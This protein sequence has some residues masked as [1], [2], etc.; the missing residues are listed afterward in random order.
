MHEARIDAALVDRAL[1][2]G[3]RNAFGQLVRRHQSVIRA[4]LRRLTQGDHARAD[5]LAQETFLKA[6]RSL[7]QFRGEA[8]FSTWLHRIA[9]TI[10]LQETRSRNNK[11]LPQTHL[12]T[13]TTGESGRHELRLDVLA[14]MARLAE[15]E[16]LALLHCYHLD[17][18][19]EEAAF[20]LRIPVGTVKTH[21][22]RGKV[23]MK[24][25]LAAWN[26]TDEADHD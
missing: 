12:N 1:K 14:A 13:G 7:H 23:K 20:V 11:R 24:E 19:H 18:S 3:D 9:Y 6:W 4:Q 21:I 8:R 5:D 17:L 26:P 15:G 22:A 25:W 10:F 16:R 2:A